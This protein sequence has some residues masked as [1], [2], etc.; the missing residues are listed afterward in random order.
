[1]SKRGKESIGF[2]GIYE[3]HPSTGPL[4]YKDKGKDNYENIINFADLNLQCYPKNGCL[5]DPLSYIN[6]QY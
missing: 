6:D 2:E 3:F 4:E 5:R 1:M